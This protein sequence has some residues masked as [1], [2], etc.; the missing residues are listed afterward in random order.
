LIKGFKE[1]LKENGALMMGMT[2]LLIFS[3]MPS[4]NFFPKNGADKDFGKIFGGFYLIG[5]WILLS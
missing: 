2:F 5:P 4:Q 1:N 3:K